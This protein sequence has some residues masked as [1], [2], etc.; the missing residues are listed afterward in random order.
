MDVISAMLGI[1]PEDRPMVQRWSH[2]TL[3]R[4]PNDPNPP[5]DVDVL[6]DDFAYSLAQTCNRVCQSTGNEVSTMRD[7]LLILI[8]EADNAS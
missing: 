1:P 2:L 5:P 8:D 7:G 3:H 6:L 4:E